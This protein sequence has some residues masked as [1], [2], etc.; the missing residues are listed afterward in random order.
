MKASKESDGDVGAGFTALG[1]DSSIVTAL[2]SLGY[3]EPTPIQRAAIPPLLEGRDLLGQAATGTGKTAAFALPL[4]QHIAAVEKSQRRYVSALVLTPTRELAIQVAE[5]IQK[6]GRGLAVTVLPIYGGADIRPQLRGLSR[7]VDVVVATPGRAVDL[8]RRKSLVLQHVRMVVLDEAD[9]MLDMGFAEDLELILKEIPAERQTALF[10][11]TMAPRVS[12]IAKQ[13]LRNPVPITIA[14]DVLQ[15]GTIPR[16][17]QLAYIVP[18]LY[19]TE[20]LGRVLDLERPASA[21]I[22]CRTRTEVDELTETVRKRG[23]RVAALHGGMSQVQ[24]DRVMKQ[25]RANT[26][27]LL[28]ATDVAA[29][30]LNVEHLACVVNYDVPTSPEAYVHRIGRTGRAGRGGIAITLAEPRERGYLTT[31]ERATKQRFEFTAV[32]TNADVRTHRLGATR[33]QIREI[34]SSGEIET[35]RAVVDALAENATVRDIAAAAIKV[36]YDAQGTLGDTSADIPVYDVSTGN[37]ANEHGKPA[38]AGRPEAWTKSKKTKTQKRFQRDAD[39]R[40]LDQRKPGKYKAAKHKSDTDRR[41]TPHGH[42][43]VSG[44]KGKRMKSKGRSSSR[45]P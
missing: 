4:L 30:G 45:R 12:M 9:E 43:A 15:A 14:R 6:Y 21:L 34:L 35:F 39:R 26:I 36:A 2:T 8:I 25:F 32:P 28:V 19:K 10:S 3:E 40:E 7:S 44:R 33:D 13:H 11:A 20:T 22:F 24:R 27:Q 29:R 41:Y 42:E 5:A 17:R 23:Y 31:L 16:V 38:K 37:P 1:L 18:R